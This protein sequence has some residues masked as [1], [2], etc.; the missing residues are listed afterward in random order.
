MGL[1]RVKQVDVFTTTPLAGNSAGV[2]LQGESFTPEEMQMIAKELNMA[3]VSFVVSSNSTED[4]IGVRCFNSSFE[5]TEAGYSLLASFHCL[6]EEKKIKPTD[7]N[8]WYCQLHSDSS[9]IPVSIESINGLSKVMLHFEPQSYEKKSE[10]KVD[11]VRLLNISI[12]DFDSNLT[13]QKGSVLLVPIR[14]LYTIYNMKPNFAAIGNFLYTR[15]ID[16]IFVYTLETLERESILHGRC[17]TSSYGTGEEPATLR[18]YVPLASYLFEKGCLKNN[19]GV[20]EFIAEQGDEM[21]RK[22]RVFGEI[23]FQDEKP[24][25]IKLGGFAVTVMEGELKLPD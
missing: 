7:R 22:G 24:K 23:I 2:V 17:F 3:E 19:N 11:L 16:G 13:I 21:G 15:K 12:G 20:C 6:L 4:K 18:A 10:Y 9:P 5:I 14:R 25:I 8:M 1:V